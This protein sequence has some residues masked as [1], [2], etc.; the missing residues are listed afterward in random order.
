VL[1]LAHTSHFLWA[2]YIPPFLIVGVA[3][4][5]S[6]AEQ[7]RLRREE[8]GGAETAPPPPA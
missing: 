5:R 3:I 1:V 2:I 4:A 7:R 6:V 8:A